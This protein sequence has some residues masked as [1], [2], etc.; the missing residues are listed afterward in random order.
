MKKLSVPTF[1]IQ[2]IKRVKKAV[3]IL[4][5]DT[6][7][8]VT[9]DFFTSNYFYP[10]KKL[11]PSELESIQKASRYYK[12]ESYLNKI[13]SSKR[14]TLKEAD[15]KLK[16]HSDLIE[17]ERKEVLSS[18]QN[19]GLISD[20]KYAQDY[21]VSLS[22]NGYG[23]RYIQQKLSSKGISLDIIPKDL[24]VSSNKEAMKIAL[25][26]LPK[27]DPLDKPLVARKNH[28]LSFLERRGFN[29]E[30]CASLVKTYFSSLSEEENIEASILVKEKLSSLCDKYHSQISRRECDEKII[31]HKLVSKLISLGYKYEEIKEVIKMKGYT[32]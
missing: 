32:R 16:A 20:E 17:K 14:Y 2:D 11:K 22:S 29:K 12:A 25:S 6:E 1:E 31:E 7:Y 13:L 27:K 5:G 18:Y 21:L 8:K 10:N 24:I 4:I 19:C 23:T 9:E 28:L 30:N 26:L 15:E 3:V